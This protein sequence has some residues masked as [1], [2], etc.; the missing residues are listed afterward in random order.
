LV[1]PVIKDPVFEGYK[2]LEQKKSKKTSFGKYMYYVADNLYDVVTKKSKPI[3]TITD[4]YIA[5][6][7]AHDI[8]HGYRKHG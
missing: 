3:C 6:K 1:H 4:A 2:V 5:Q 7:V 8:A